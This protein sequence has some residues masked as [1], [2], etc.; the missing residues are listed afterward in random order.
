MKSTIIFFG[1]CL[2]ASCHGGVVRD[3]ET[4]TIYYSSGKI[5][6][7]IHIKYGVPNGLATF[8]YESGSIE[9]I[10]CFRNGKAEGRW[11][12]YFEAISDSTPIINGVEN[13]KSGKWDGIFYLFYPS[14]HLRTTANF[15]NDSLNSYL[16]NYYDGIDRPSECYPEVK[17]NGEVDFEIQYD[18]KGNP[19]VLKGRDNKSFANF[20]YSHSKN[21][22]TADE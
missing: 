9:A 18:I 5:H 14:G 21:K 22:I 7:E 10:G 11:V 13:Y 17:H 20:Q 15:E 2:L 19:Q 1:V 3:N 4:K 12:R 8:Y 6:K 16:L